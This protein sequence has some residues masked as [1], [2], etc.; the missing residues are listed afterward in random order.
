MSRRTCA[1]R[2]MALA[3]IFILMPARAYANVVWPG[4]VAGWATLIWIVPAGLLIEYFVVQKYLLPN[5]AGRAVI[6]ANIA[7]ALAGIVLF[8][9]LGTIGEI[10]PQAVLNPADGYLPDSAVYH[11]LTLVGLLSFAA[12]A[13]TLIEGFLMGRMFN[14]DLSGRT[15]KILY[16]GNFASTAVACAMAALFMS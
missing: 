10:V 13:S 15:F 16:W 4:L 14:L 3:A 5:D 9:F 12:L 11:R 1:F 7:S 2:I 8:P 6:L